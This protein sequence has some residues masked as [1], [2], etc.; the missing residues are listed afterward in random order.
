VRRAFG[1]AEGLF[2]V[3]SRRLSGQLDCFRDTFHV[4]YS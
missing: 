4:G 2:T 1:H 3:T